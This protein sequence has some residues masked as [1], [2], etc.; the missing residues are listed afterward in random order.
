MSLG[1][2]KTPEDPVSDADIVRTCK[3]H[4]ER[5]V[6]PYLGIKPGTTCWEATVLLYS[7]KL[8]CH[9]QTYVFTNKQNNKKMLLEVECE[10]VL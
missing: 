4:R 6:F 1:S 3:L 2:G 7:T 5:H 9:N 8:P 10:V